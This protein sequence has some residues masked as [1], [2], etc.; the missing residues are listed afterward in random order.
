MQPSALTS[1]LLERAGF[2]HA[3]FTRHGGV[4]QGAYS[5]MNFAW[6]TGDDREL[7]LENVRRA[8]A[9]LG[10]EPARLFYL[11]QVHGDVCHTVSADSRW[12]QVLLI[13]GDAI[14]SRDTR[15]A[16]GVRTAD[17]VPILLA[18]AQTGAV[19]AIHAGWRGAE[20]DIAARAIEHLR[21]MT[22]EPGRLIA[23]IGPHISPSAFEIGDEVAERIERA[24]PATGVVLRAAGQKPHADLR[25]MVE[26]Q[27]RRAG[28]AEVDHVQGCTVNEPELYFSFRRDGAR[29][30]RH[31]AAIVPR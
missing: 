27:L 3:F 12:D 13:E 6:S 15:V 30:G 28:V 25:A 5:S 8:A 26:A 19:S 10:V 29:S 18:D 4:S 14:A 24:S 2:R 11:S 17:C 22:G 31:L 20:L 1:P 21:D 23:A 9:R 7:V 16:C